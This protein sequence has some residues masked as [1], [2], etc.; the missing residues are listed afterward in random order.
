[1]RIGLAALP[2]GRQPNHAD[3]SRGPTPGAAGRIGSY[4][5]AHA[6][7]RYELRL[8]V[9]HGDEG[10]ALASYGEVVEGI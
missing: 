7:D 1:M 10:A 5:A 4:F 8:M 9:R 3:W 2:A 6:H